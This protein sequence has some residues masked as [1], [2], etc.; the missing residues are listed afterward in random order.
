MYTRN[1]GAETLMVG[2]YVDDMIVTGTIL[3]GVKEFKQKMM[4][5]FFMTD[6][7]LLT[8]YLCIEVDQK[9]YCIMLK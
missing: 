6:L 5:E 8:Y 4:K 3:D 1:N 9:K 2:M 7:G